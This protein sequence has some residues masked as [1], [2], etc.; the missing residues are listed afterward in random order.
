MAKDKPAVLDQRFSVDLALRIARQVV[1]EGRG[2]VNIVII[3]QPQGVQL[4]SDN[5]QQLAISQNDNP[6]GTE[7]FDDNIKDMEVY[8]LKRAI[9]MS[10]GIKA[11]AAK[12]LGMKR[13]TFYDKCD[14]YGIEIS[15][16]G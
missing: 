9:H 13:Q 3:N 4:S 1:R 12:M 15:T 7:N 5:S 10:K 14:K 11:H 8:L 6:L 2:N 16:E